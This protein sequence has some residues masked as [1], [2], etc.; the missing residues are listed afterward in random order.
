MLGALEASTALYLYTADP[1]VTA[2]ALRDT[3]S[4]EQL[5]TLEMWRRAQIKQRRTA[6]Q[7]V[8]SLG[9]EAITADTARIGA[10]TTAVVRSE[11]PKTQADRTI[12]QLVGFEM[13]DA[14]WDGNE[15]ARPLGFSIK[16]AREFIRALAPESIIPRPALHADGHAILFIR[17]PDSYAELEFLGARRIGFYARRGEKEW[18][19]E[20][21]FDG[22]ALP[23]GLSEIG[24]AI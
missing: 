13:L 11:E 23:A 7:D 19:E 10:S 22:R 17:G 18:G 5:I 8:S 12:A 16:D 4:R 9:D 3:Q 1:S 6:A 24:F 2:I 14:D 15:A 21:S 20:F